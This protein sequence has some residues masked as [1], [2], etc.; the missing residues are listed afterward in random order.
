MA[1]FKLVISD[2]KSGKSLQKE[3]KDDNAKRLIGAK[4][5]DTVKGELIDMPGY[6]FQITGGSDYAG[7][8]MRWDVQGN[9]RK[10]ITAVKGVGVHNKRHLP[11]P[12]KK[13]M[14]TMAG[15]RLKKTVAGNTVHA[16]TAQIN[17]K[18]TKQGREKLFAEE[19]PAAEA[20]EAKPE[21]AA[22]ESDAP[23]DKGGNKKMTEEKEVKEPE[24]VPEK[25]EEVAEK[26]EEVPIGGG[27]NVDAASEA[28]TE[29][30][31]EAP[32]EK[33]K[34]EPK[35]KPAEEKEEKD[36]T[37]KTMEELD[38]LDKEVKKDEE[39]IEKESE[40]IEKIEKE[41]KESDSEA[42]DEGKK[43]E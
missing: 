8:P 5:G 24:T 40:E 1:E 29:K 20:K 10:R 2:P 4:I 34:E 37:E 36:D 6:E 41:L 12:K 27:E 19:A 23:K 31:E 33:K 38:E 22:K 3:V 15:M 9:A 18:V 42:G 26:V 11:N 13:G 21:K 43:E 16:K 14:R 39:E 35:P 25:A 17:L 32:K 7:F 28:P 30:T